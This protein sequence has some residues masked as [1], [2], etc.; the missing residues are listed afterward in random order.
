MHTKCLRQWQKVSMR[1]R[2]VRESVVRQSEHYDPRHAADDVAAA[3]AVGAKPALA[4]EYT[5][6]CDAKAPDITFVLGGRRYDLALEDYVIEE[7]GQCLFGMM[8]IDIPAPNGPLWILG[9]VFMR[10]YYVK[11]DIKGEQIGIATAKS[12]KAD[13]GY[14]TA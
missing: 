3:K 1:T 14:A 11:F 13:V 12:S 2:G 6:A 4:G 10:K 8:G 7:S 9:D 5:I